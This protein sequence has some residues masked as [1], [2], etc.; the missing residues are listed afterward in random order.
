MFDSKC[1]QPNLKNT[2]W[3]GVQTGNFFLTKK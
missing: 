1:K 3:G 2:Y